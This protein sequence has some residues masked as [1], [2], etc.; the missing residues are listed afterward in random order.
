MVFMDGLTHGLFPFLGGKV[1]NRN[2]EE[3]A[4][5][6]LGGIAPDFDLFI[7]WIP[8]FFQTSI[9]FTHRGITHTFIFGFLTAAIVL[10]IASRK[11]FQNLLAYAFRTNIRLAMQHKLLVFVYLGVLSH[12]FLDWITTRGIPLFYP[13]S[14]IR[15]SAEVFYYIDVYLMIISAMLVGFS[16]FKRSRI[17]KSIQKERKNSHVPSKPQTLEDSSQEMRGNYLKMFAVLIAAILILGGLRY[18]EKGVS[19][20]YFGVSM[21]NIFPSP[22]PFDWRVSDANAGK[23]YEFDSLDRKVVSERNFTGGNPNT[24]GRYSDD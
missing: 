1:F 7:T 24:F 6:L 12:L 15:Y 21:K 16:F 10:F 17:I 4:A 5:L 3:C 9:P 14:T 8:L 22:N 11:Y 18:Y 20:G 23:L 2:R 19:A 13:F